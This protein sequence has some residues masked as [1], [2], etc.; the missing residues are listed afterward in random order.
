MVGLLTEVTMGGREL[1][2]KGSEVFLRQLP[3]FFLFL[4]RMIGV[5]AGDD[6]WKGVAGEEL[7]EQQARC[8][9]L[10]QGEQQ[11]VTALIS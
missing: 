8:P 2:E 5:L 6:V 9:L 7:E 1:Q 10:Q 11:G 4:L 3:D